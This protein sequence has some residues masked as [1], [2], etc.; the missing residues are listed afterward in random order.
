VRSK[1]GAAAPLPRARAASARRLTDPLTA[2]CD[3]LHA[4]LDGAGAAPRCRT[5]NN[6]LSSSRQSSA[7]RVWGRSDLL[8]RLLPVDG[9]VFEIQSM[10]IKDHESSAASHAI[11]ALAMRLARREVRPVLGA[12]LTLCYLLPGEDG[13]LPFEGMQLSTHDPRKGVVIIEAC[14]PSH[15]VHDALRAGPYVL[16]VAAD[17]I[18]A[19]REFFVE[20]GITAFDADAL[21][22]WIMT[23]K[24]ADLLPPQHQRVRNTDFEWS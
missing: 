24:A 2:S 22:A 7:A 9:F 5:S 17:A 12:Q 6:G 19:A 13:E 1:I 20:Q 8:A 4:P 11:T 16:A 18:D 15:V 21:H 23:V 14:V 10:M 3:E